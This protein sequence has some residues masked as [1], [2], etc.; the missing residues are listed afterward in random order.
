MDRVNEDTM[1]LHLTSQDFDGKN[2]IMPGAPPGTLSSDPAEELIALTTDGCTSAVAVMGPSVQIMLKGE[3]A[4]R[5]D[6]RSK[7]Q[8]TTLR[9]PHA[10][11]RKPVRPHE[12]EVVGCNRPRGRSF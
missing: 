12:S 1:F 6:E 11:L 8:L 3:S 2:F 5:D 4:L 10:N 7:R 9:H